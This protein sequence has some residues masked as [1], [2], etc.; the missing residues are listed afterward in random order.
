MNNQ[1]LVRPHHISVTKKGNVISPHYIMATKKQL[2]HLSPSKQCKEKRIKIGH[3]F[4]TYERIDQ[5]NVSL[6]RIIAV[7]GR[8]KL[9]LE[10]IITVQKANKCII[11][12]NKAEKKHQNYQYSRSYYC[13]EKHK[14][15]NTY[16][17]SEMYKSKYHF[18]PPICVSEN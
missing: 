18:F 15:Q 7:Q 13:M 5:P 12:A 11:I 8:T 9:S 2:C 16:S 1:N 17:I 4:P 3:Y 14:V 10:H 6:V